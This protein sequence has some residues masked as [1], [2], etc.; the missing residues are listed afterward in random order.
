MA[1]CAADSAAWWRRALA[2]ARKE[3]LSARLIAGPV[4]AERFEG[5]DDRLQAVL[6]AAQVLGKALLALGA[7]LGDE[8]AVGGGL[9]PVDWQEHGRGLEVRAGQAGVGVRAVLLGGAGA[10]AVGQAVADPVEVV[11]DPLGRGSGGVGVIADPLPADVGPLGLVAVE[12][13]PDGGVVD[14]G[15]VA[16]HVRAGMAGGLLHHML[17]DA[18]VDQPRPECVTELV[19]GHGDRLP[20]LVAQADD[21]LPAPELLG[22]GAVRVRLGTVVVAGHAGEQ[23]GAARW[24]ALAH[25]VLLGTGRRRRRGA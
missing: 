4:V 13:L 24:P 25:V 2:W 8:T 12:C 23:P 7:G 3:E 21:P 1:W 20:G 15:V 5:G 10:V 18:G 9:P 14:L 17:G 6:N 19:G 16:G 11:L 22:E